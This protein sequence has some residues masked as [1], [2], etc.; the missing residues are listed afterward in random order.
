MLDS[1]SLGISTFS[2]VLHRLRFHYHQCPHHQRRSQ[3]AQFAQS[4]I[5]WERNHLKPNSDCIF[6]ETRSVV[7]IGTDS[8]DISVPQSVNFPL[9]ELNQPFAVKCFSTLF[10]E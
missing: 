3:V 2:P 5:A 7:W 10:R 4:M 9:G 1:H 6:D 8:A